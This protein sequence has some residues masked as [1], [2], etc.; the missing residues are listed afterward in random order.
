MNTAELFVKSLESEGV[1]YIFAVPG[2]ENLTFLE[3]LRKSKIKI[4]VTRHEQ[5]AGFMAATVGR[6]TGSPGV[7]LTTLGPGATNA[8]TAVAYAQLGG[9][10]TL[11][12]TGQKGIHTSK[13]GHF[14]IINTVE[15]LSPITKYTKQIVGGDSVPSLVRNAFRIAREERP[16]AVHLELPEDVAL[17]PVEATP[18]TPVSVRRPVAEEKALQQAVKMI[19]EAKHPLLVIGAGSNRKRT[20]LMLTK[21][22]EKTG[23]YFVTTQMGKGVVDERHPQYLGTTALSDNDYIHCGLNRADLIINVGHDIIEKPPFLM[24]EGDKRKVLHI[25]FFAAVVDKI[26]TPQWEVIGD[27]ANT[28]YELTKRIEPQK[29]WD[30][31]YFKTLTSYLEKHISSLVGKNK[32]TL[33]PQ[34]VVNIIRTALPEDGI[35]TLDNGMYKIWF[36]RNYPTYAENTLLLDNALATMGAGMPSAL[37]V[38]L[39]NPT[40][41]VV[42]VVGDGGFMMTSQDLETA[43]RLNLDL[44]IVLLRDDAYGMI[45]WKQQSMHLPSFAL[46]FTNPDFKLLADAYGINGYRIKDASDFKKTLSRTLNAKGIHLLDVPIDYKDNY[47]VLVEDLQKKTCVL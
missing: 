38:K 41:K 4:I 23:I 35:V 32:K 24:T 2:E 21:F 13:Q 40:K 8:I 22:I 6:L 37:A 5:T 18:L 14:Q 30:F 11:F 34:D 17:M 12:I 36:A 42:A 3:A 25:N 47:K 26:Y 39:L 15:I 1:K 29:K 44:V 7:C 19:Q 31:S 28:I 20:S 10:P 33:K 45:K 16:G 27:I 43:K 9:M 46:D